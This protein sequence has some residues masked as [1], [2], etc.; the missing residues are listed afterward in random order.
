M[1]ALSQTPP[2]ALEP[3][4]T[5]LAAAPALAEI[6]G[7]RGASL[8][9]ASPAQPYVLAGLAHHRKEGP[10][11]VVTP[12]TAEADQLAEDIGCF[13]GPSG[14]P[15][16]SG[17]GAG[18]GADAD[19]VVGDVVGPVA[20]LPAWDTLPFERVS[21]E[22][23]TMG[24]RLAVLWHLLGA[25]SDPPAVVVASVRALLQSLPDGERVPGPVSV[26]SGSELDAS[27]L[28]QRLVS[29]GY[30]REYQVE[31]RG[32][33]AVRGGIVDVFPSTADLP[34]RID[35]WGDE[36]DRLTVFDPSDQRSVEQTRPRRALRMPGGLR[37]GCVSGAGGDADRG[38]SPGGGPVGAPRGGPALRRHGVVAAVAPRAS[39]G[40]PTSSVRAA[41]SCSSN[42]G[43]SA[44]GPSSSP[45]RR[46][47]R[48][49]PRR[50]RGGSR[51]HAGEDDSDS[52]RLAPAFRASARGSSA[53]VLVARARSPRDPINPGRGARVRARTA[54]D[55]TRLCRAGRV[56]LGARIAD[57]LLV[58]ADGRSASALASCSASTA[59][60]S[61]SSTSPIR[62]PRS[63]GGP[64]AV[65]PRL[66]PSR[67]RRRGAGRGRPHRPPARPSPGPRPGPADRRLLRRP[68]GRGLR[69]APPARRRPLRRRWSRAPSAG[70]SATTCC[71]STAAATSSTCRRTRSTPSPP[72]PAARRRR[73]TASAAPSGSAARARARAA[74][75]EIA[76]ELV[77]LYRRRLDVPGHAF[78]PDTPWQRE[79][80]ASFPYIETPDQLRAIAEVKADMEA[81]APMDRLVCGDVGFGKTEVA[82]RAVF[83]AVQD[84]K[85]AAVLVP[86]TLLAQQHVQTFSRALR[87][88]PGAGRDAVAASSPRPRPDK[89]VAGLADGSVDVVI[90]THRLLAGDV[91]FKDLGLLV[92]DEEQRFGVTH[93]EAIKQLAPSVDVL[94]LTASPIPRTLEMASPASATCRSSTRRPADR[95][96]ILTYVGEYDERAVVEAIRREL[97]REGQVV[98]RAQP[99][100]GHRSGGRRLRVLVPEARVAVAHGQMDEGTLEQVVLDFWEQALRRAGVHDDHRVG[101]RHA[102]GQHARRRPG[103]PARARP[104][105]PAARPGGAG[106]AARLRLPVPPADRVLT[107]QA[108]E[109]LKTIGE[110]TELGCGVQDRHARP[111]DPRGGNLLGADQSGHIA[112]VGYDLYVQLVAEAVAE[113]KGEPRPRA[114]RDQDRPA[115]RRA[116]PGRLRAGRGPAPRGLPAAGRGR[117][118]TPRSTTSRRSGSTAS[119]RCPRPPRGCCRVARLRVECLRIGITEVSVD[120]PRPAGRGPGR[121]ARSSR[122]APPVLRGLGA[123]SAAS[124]GARGPLQGGRPPVA[125]GPCRDGVVQPTSCASCMAS[126]AAGAPPTGC[127]Q[128]DSVPPGV[129][130]LLL[131]LVVVGRRRRGPPTFTVP[132]NAAN[133]NGQ[134]ISQ[135]ALNSDLAAIAASPEY[136]CAL[137]C[138][139][140][141]AVPRPGRAAARQRGG[142]GHLRLD[143]RHLLAEPHDR[144]HAP[145]AAGRRRRVVLTQSQ[146][147]SARTEALQSLQ[148]TLNEVAGTQY[149]CQVTPSAVLA[150]VPSSFSSELIAARGLQ[151]SPGRAVLGRR[152]DRR[153]AASLLLGTHLGL[154]HAVR[155]RHPR[156]EPE[157]GEP[158]PEPDR[159]GSLLLADRD[160]E[161]PGRRQRS[162]GRRPRVLLRHLELVCVGQAGRG[163]ALDRRR[164]RAD[165]H[166]GRWSTS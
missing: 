52:P 85:Q 29:L 48:R 96:P 6:H 108:Y 5:R 42:P 50:R 142:L 92:V 95:R 43:G 67:S 139:D 125:G 146:L 134:T 89:V 122:I 2:A 159:G 124:P 55:P 120:A 111:R 4:L 149:Q 45:T 151:R 78:A 84:G 46:R 99:G 158:A 26:A 156:P 150:S 102:H 32:E 123:G 3:L 106:R 90:G 75:H 17:P 53:S 13:L 31:H 8:A 74:V 127:R 65:V 152:H 143:L 68:A 163:L 104:A 166:L 118:P 77:A 1:S 60:S 116:P 7:S 21:P 88:L 107:E 86:T 165:R 14:G 126:L 9:V 93:K 10:L 112:A 153:L 30:R 119:A 161:F 98:L 109:R 82:V 132:S 130:R 100:A 51:R 24:Q 80:E 15:G 117:R 49:R 162:Q 136:Q 83:K 121:P 19:R 105:P 131:L 97:L 154:R 71:S 79:L 58:A 145:P 148:T 56:A 103:R 39:S 64:L 91:R 22:V 23:H 44:T 16:R 128:A 81:T 144:R 66:C 18:D 133:V 141:R 70:P 140:R 40:C 114:R 155:Q 59:S 73:S 41:R 101:H 113:L 87:R 57:A 20:L 63:T 27:A 11:V 135:S 76:Q 38:A 33:L 36:V 115:R 137:N 61:R 147:S 72:T 47:P 160:G 28:V 164:H 69:R 54:G 37:H 157:S 34:V 62:R 138:R 35:L 12:T 94:T 25:G 129:K 110:H